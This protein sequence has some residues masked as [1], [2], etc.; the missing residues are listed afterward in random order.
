M[1]DKIF[2]KIFFKK[3]SDRLNPVYINKYKR[4]KDRYPNITEYLARHGRTFREALYNIKYNINQVPIC[5]V[6]GKPLKFIG[7]GDTL[8]QKY[9][10]NAC[11]AKSKEWI[12]GQS[13]NAKKQAEKQ[14]EHGGYYITSDNFKKKRSKTLIDKYGTDNV[15]DI[16]GMSDRIKQS[17]LKKYGVDNPM[18][19]PEFS[20]KQQQALINK[21]GYPNPMLVPELREKRI[22]TMRENNSFNKSQSEEI[23]YNKLCNIFP[24]VKR[25]YSSKLYPYACDFYIPDLDL[26]IEYNGTWT[27]G[28]HFFEKN[29]SDDINIL[30]EWTEKSKTSEYYRNAIYTWTIRD[31]EKY[32]TVIKNNVNLVWLWNMKEA[33]LFLKIFLPCNIN[34]IYKELNYYKTVK[35]DKDSL[36]TAPAFTYTIKYFQQL[37]FFRRERFFWRVPQIRQRLI[38]NRI[39]YLNKTYD[40]LSA[41]DILTGFKKSGIFYGYSHFNP[42]ILKYICDRFKVKK[43]YDPCSGWGHHLLGCLNIDKYIYNDPSKQ[44][45]D[46]VKRMCSVLNIKNV[47]VHS[48]DCRKY[49]PKQDFDAMFVCPPYF[50]KEKNINLEDYEC[51]GFKDINEY[52]KFIDNF[53]EIFYKKESCRVFA[54]V[55]RE[56]MLD[57]VKYPPSETID[58]INR[59]SHLIQEKKLKEKLY[60]YLK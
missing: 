39:K 35:P 20:K 25:Q 51:G 9:C 33:E 32:D 17:F 14:K 24:D 6:C 18:K 57:T 4:N 53:F 47:T 37:N 23:I 27:H 12:A 36:Q 7:K 21:Y 44:T 5:P 2:L 52:N 42:L 16:P 13:A 19:N 54:I 10:S 38:D 48:N 45:A 30:N 50:D 29:N 11:R 60:I 46:A 56:D 59:K 41:N 26:Y 1:D 28:G 22:E 40:E 34:N 15:W 43:L 58:L 3:N 49:T 8:Y 55:I 31:P